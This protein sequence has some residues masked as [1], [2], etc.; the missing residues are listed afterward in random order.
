MRFFKRKSKVDD[1]EKVQKE[2]HQPVPEPAA[3]KSY[4]TLREALREETVDDNVAREHIFYK[5]GGNIIVSTIG[6]TV[7][8]AF[9]L[10]RYDFKSRF[11]W[12]DEIDAEFSST[13]SE[14]TGYDILHL[15]PTV[16][17]TEDS[18]T[19]TVLEKI[20]RAYSLRILCDLDAEYEQVKRVKTEVTPIDQ[21]EKVDFLELDAKALNLA[22]DASRA[23]TVEQTLGLHVVNKTDVRVSLGAKDFTPRT[24]EE[25]LI[26]TVAERN[27]TLSDLL[28]SSELFNWADLME[29]FHEVFLAEKIEF[30]YPHQEQSSA[31]LR[32]DL[33]YVPEPVPEPEPVTEEVQDV[34]DSITTEDGADANRDVPTVESPVSPVETVEED[35][36]TEG[37]YSFP[38]PMPEPVETNETLPS[39]A[40]DDVNNVEEPATTAEPTVPYNEDE[41][42]EAIPVVAEVDAPED[43]PAS[44]EEVAVS[45]TEQESDLP[46]APYDRSS[47]DP[48]QEPLYAETYA[49]IAEHNHHDTSTV[50]DLTEDAE[51]DAIVEH[52]A[53]NDEL[54]T[55]QSL[56]NDATDVTLPEI[57]LSEASQKRPHENDNVPKAYE[58]AQSILRDIQQKTAPTPQPSF[59][60]IPDF[61]THEKNT[62]GSAFDLNEVML[63]GKNIP[64]NSPLFDKLAKERGLD[65]PK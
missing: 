8:F 25:H 30:E 11:K 49:H 34:V 1:S 32:E 40:A 62:P 16:E 31:A 20:F 33:L 59:G 24:G 46:A 57:D 44:S 15:Y 21:I 12:S 43:I 61:S 65:F 48:T 17:D 36:D 5:P 42:T 54:S 55:T 52:D 28:E 47:Y 4:E 10:S 7:K 18:S 29:A 9:R 39:L 37:F 19:K 38:V 6:T 27:L 22:P 56:D 50:E 64:E 53:Q 58:E 23:D 45:E 2:E 51:I 13:P 63:K 35:S 26:R 60:E 3:P 14:L 41:V